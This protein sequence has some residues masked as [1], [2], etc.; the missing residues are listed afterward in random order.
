[1]LRVQ[2]SKAK[3][4]DLKRIQ[5]LNQKLFRKEF[6]EYDRTLNIN[7][8][9]EKDGEKYFKKR[10]RNGCVLVAVQRDEVIGYLCGGL[11]EMGSFKKNVKVAELENM[12]ILKDFRSKGIGSLLCKY[13]L[14]WC[15]NRNVERIRVEAYAKNEKGIKF[16]EEMGLKKLLVTLET[17]IFHKS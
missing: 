7:W 6:K 15:R 14:E 12:F 5:T 3:V 4:S 17:K 2:I 13:F 9:F 8:P 16:Y 1:M 11:K 10:L